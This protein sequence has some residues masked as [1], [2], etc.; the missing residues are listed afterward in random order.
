MRILR[1]LAFALIFFACACAWSAPQLLIVKLVPNDKYAD[2]DPND[3]LIQFIAQEFDDDGRVLPIAWGISDPYFRAAVDDKILVNPPDKPDLE[4]AQRTASKL[5][6]DYLLVV[7]VR[8]SD[9]SLFAVATLYRR[10]KEIWRDP[11]RNAIDLQAAN[12]K[13]REIAEKI[14]RKRK[15]HAPDEPQAVPE[16][17]EIKITLTGRDNDNELRSLARTWVTFL[18]DGA[19]KSLPAR[20]KVQ[21]QHIDPGQKP[22]ITA[23]PPPV[24]KVDNKQ[25]LADATKLLSAKHYP[26]AISMLR[27]A[28]DTEPMDVER[29]RALV[30]ALLEGGDPLVAAQEARRAAAILPD[31]A[32]L[33]GLAARA[34]MKAGKPD[35]ALAELNESVAHDPNSIETR[36]LIGELDL[37]SAK[38]ADAGSQF[39]F[40]ISKAAFPDAF[41]DRAVVKCLS[42]DQDGAGQDLASANQHGLASDPASVANRY[43]LV[44]S[45][46]DSVFKEFGPR[47][48]S[49]LQRVRVRPNDAEVTTDIQDAAK[50][51]SAYIAFLEPLAAPPAHKA[52]HERQ[53]LALK[54]LAQSLS[55]MEDYQKAQSEETL[56][57]ATISLG[58]GLKNLTQAKTDYEKEISVQP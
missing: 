22:P 50:K 36:M 28:V 52:S 24:H 29:R 3:N 45:A 18:S 39:D 13:N 5:K 27:D 12:E 20:P 47:L 8:Q 16:G 26:E 57:D 7:T 15:E 6:A 10:G 58:E 35:E 53:L 33:H 51:V 21:I 25:L 2:G 32:E 37:G 4:E 41:F 23:D 30:L 19:L 34:F 11:D 56:S 42:A 46:F 31:Q 9:L 48:R 54:L 40:V 1:S 17:R 55:D 43:A 49:D 14:A 38:Y 44:S